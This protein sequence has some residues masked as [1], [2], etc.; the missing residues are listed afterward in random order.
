MQNGDGR[1]T[2]VNIRKRSPPPIHILY[3][4]NT[5]RSRESQEAAALGETNSPPGLPWMH[6]KQV[7]EPASNNGGRAQKELGPNTPNTQRYL[8]QPPW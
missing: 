1:L 2:P 3:L 6:G 5:S 4:Q 7:F 8:D